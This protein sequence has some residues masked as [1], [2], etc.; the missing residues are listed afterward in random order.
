MHTCFKNITDAFTAASSARR[1]YR[2]S[3]HGRT[4]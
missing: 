2:G 4:A 3:A 1:T